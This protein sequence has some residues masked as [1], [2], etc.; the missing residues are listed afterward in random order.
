[1]LGNLPFVLLNRCR[2]PQPHVPRAVRVMNLAAT[3]V[4][5]VH[6]GLAAGTLRLQRQPLG[7]ASDAE[8]FA[9][10]V[11]PMGLADTQAAG[12]TGERQVDRKSTRLNSSHLGIS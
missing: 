5:H 6:V 1:M 11:E 2:R 10:E 3:R 8:A 7:R 12:V 9:R 4:E